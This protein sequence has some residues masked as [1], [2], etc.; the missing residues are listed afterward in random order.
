MTWCILSYLLRMLIH[1]IHWT[2]SSPV[3]HKMDHTRVNLIWLKTF[4]LKLDFAEHV[5]YTDVQIAG[6][7]EA[8]LSTIYWVT[9]YLRLVPL[10]ILTCSLNMI[11][12]AR[13]V[14][15]SLENWSFAH[16]SPRPPLR[17]NFLHGVQVLVR[18]YLCVRFDVP[19]SINF[20]DINGFPKLEAW[21]PY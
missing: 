8:P 14:S 9:S 15:G 18:G 12:L 17:K 5:Q 13:L 2:R 21:N 6:F 20:R 11:F 10:S 19:S 16:R 7:W 3:T 1:R 4:E